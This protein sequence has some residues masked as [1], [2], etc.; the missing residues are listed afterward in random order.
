MSR[1]ICQLEEGHNWFPLEYQLSV[2]PL[3]KKN[4]RKYSPPETQAS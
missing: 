3:P 2:E 1:E 4:P